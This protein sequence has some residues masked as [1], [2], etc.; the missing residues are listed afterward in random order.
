MCPAGCGSGGVYYRAINVTLQ[1]SKYTGAPLGSSTR[2]LTRTTQDDEPRRFLL[3]P[4]TYFC[5][6]MRTHTR[7]CIEVWVYPVGAV[8]RRPKIYDFSPLKG[9]DTR[10][11]TV[12]WHV[13]TV[14]SIQDT[15]VRKE[16]H[17]GACTGTHRGDTQ[18]HTYIHIAI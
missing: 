5:L 2:S 11:E 8:T 16:T 7:A 15:E 14:G 6:E 9:F 18:G 12:G 1:H 10:P 17:R 4:Q 3:P 13:S